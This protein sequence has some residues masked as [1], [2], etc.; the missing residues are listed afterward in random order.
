VGGSQSL[1]PRFDIAFNDDIYTTTSNLERSA[2]DSYTVA[3]ARLTWRDSSRNWEAALEVTNLFDEYY[4]R[5]I[6]DAY[7][8]GHLVSGSPGRPREWAFTVKKRF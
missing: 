6:Y 8:R 4:M 3:N 5:T 2:I 7:D 1:T